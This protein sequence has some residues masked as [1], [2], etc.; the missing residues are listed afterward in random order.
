[1]EVSNE[2]V[3][4]TGDFPRL[5]TESLFRTL[6]RGHGCVTRI[7][8]SAEGHHD[9]PASQPRGDREISPASQLL[10]YLRNV[11]VQHLCVIDAFQRIR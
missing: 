5:A 6:A 2:R 1:M 3:A 8:Q 11:A 7:E 9:L 10:T 4:T